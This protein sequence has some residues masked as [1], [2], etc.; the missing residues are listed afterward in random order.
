MGSMPGWA[1]GFTHS[2]VAVGIQS[3]EQTLVEISDLGPIQTGKKEKRQHCLQ[4]FELGPEELMSCIKAG[5]L[6]ESH[7]SVAERRRCYVK[8]R[9]V[10]VGGN[11][12]VFMWRYPLRN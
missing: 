11:G 9:A 10:W 4:D 12:E 3:E 8:C 5:S 1:S 7:L 6:Q 2:G